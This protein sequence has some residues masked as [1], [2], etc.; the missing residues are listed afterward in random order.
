MLPPVQFRPWREAMTEAL[1]GPDGFY[2]RNQPAGHFRTSVT[3]G[4]LF[5]TA[6]RRLAGLVDDALG[7]PDPFDVVDLGAGGGGL[8]TA[9]PDVPARWRLGPVDAGEPWPEDAEGLVFA[10]ELLDNIPL[11]VL[12]DGRVVEV[13]AD[14]TERLGGPGSPELLAWGAQ[15]WPRS[16]RIEVGLRRDEAWSR[17]VGTVRRGLVVAVD[18]GHTAADRRTSLT[19]FRD[20]HQVAPVPDGSCDLTAHVAVDSCAATTGAATL[21]QRQALSVLGIDATPPPRQLADTDPRGYLALL[22]QSQSAAELLAPRGL[23]S[24]TWLVQPVGI[25][26]PLTDS[27]P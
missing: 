8:L 13:A 21:V 26:D 23:G 22:Q 10:N 12:F 3:A 7:H 15:W 11:D 14:G 1:Y 6:V 2:A 9:L 5:A 24:F 27:G 25:D 4:P 17:A 16:R 18:Y 20:G 19:G